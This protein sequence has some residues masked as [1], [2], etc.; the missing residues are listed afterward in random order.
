MHGMGLLSTMLDLRRLQ[1]V[2]AYTCLLMLDRLGLL[3]YHYI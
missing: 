3:R 1:R 2:E